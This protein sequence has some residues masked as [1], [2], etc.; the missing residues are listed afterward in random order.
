MFGR[1]RKITN[2]FIIS[3]RQANEW[4]VV[5]EFTSGSKQ[6]YESTLIPLVLPLFLQL[7][8]GIFNPMNPSSFGNFNPHGRRKRDINFH[9]NENMS[10]LLMSIMKQVVDS[11]DKYH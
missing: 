8:A 5:Y 9:P 4:S 6:L 10:Q 1:N 2:D 7:F 11:F 3:F